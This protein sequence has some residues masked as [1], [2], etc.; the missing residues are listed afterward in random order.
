MKNDRAVE[1]KIADHPCTSPSHSRST[2]AAER[3][4]CVVCLKASYPLDRGVCERCIQKFIQKYGEE[5]GEE[6]DL[7]GEDLGWND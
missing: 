6:S 7:D 3:D 5:F 1:Q 2:L 4:N